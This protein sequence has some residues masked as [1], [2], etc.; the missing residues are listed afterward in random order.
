MR[1]FAVH[2]IN[3][4]NAIWQS[5]NA[6]RVAWKPLLLFSLIYI[7]VDVGIKYI[8]TEVG[9]MS[10]F[11]GYFLSQMIWMIIKLF[12]VILLIKTI[13]NAIR[14]ETNSPMKVLRFVLSK[15][16]LILFQVMICCAFLVPSALIILFILMSVMAS[17]QNPTT[18]TY[19]LVG[20]ALVKI[21][22][23]IHGVIINNDDSMESILASISMTNGNF[24]IL[25]LVLIGLWFVDY[26]T[27]YAYH[28]F[29]SGP[30]SGTVGYNIAKSLMSIIQVALLTSMYHQL[31]KKSS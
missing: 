23:S 24:I 8:L 2:R 9:F 25:V 5:I 11:G 30:L 10:F 13:S 17:N 31:I 7:V 12:F 1:R 6:I 26:G 22:F 15:I 14:R 19:V 21:I 16:G 3:V 27:M 4:L 28:N 20:I 18:I 29:I